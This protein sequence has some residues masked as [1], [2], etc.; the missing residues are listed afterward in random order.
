MKRSLVYNFTKKLIG[1]SAI[2][3]LLVQSL[4]A[5]S[6]FVSVAP[7]GLP[8][9]IIISELNIDGNPA[10]AGTEIGI[11]D[12]TLCVGSV[13]TDFDGQTNIDIVTWQGNPSYDLPGFTTGNTIIFKVY[14]N[15]YGE[16]EELLVTPEF[17][18]GDGTFGY[19]SF[20]TTS[21][22][23][24]SGV[25]PQISVNTEIINFGNVQLG[26]SS[27]EELI[28]SNNGTANLSIQSINIDNSQFSIGS[29]QNQIVPGLSDTINIAFYPTSSVQTQGTMTI[30]SNDPTSPNIQISL[31]GQGLP[32]DQPTIYVSTNSVNFGSVV[33][34]DSSTEV[35][36]IFN[37]GSDTLTIT[38]IYSSHTAF[39]AS[40][41]QFSIPSGES[42]SLQITFSP[43][44]Q[45]NING[46]F[47]IY[48]NAQNSSEY[49]ISLTGYG[50]LGHFQSVE[51]T[52]LPYIIIINNAT[53][54]DHNLQVGDEIGVFDGELCVG[55]NVYTGTYPT[56]L[57][58]W[59][60]DPSANLPGFSSGNPMNI[61]LWTSTYGS[62]L[63]LTPDISWIEGDGSFGSGEYSVIEISAQSGLEP[64][65]S[66]STNS[67][68]FGETEVGHAIS[69]SFYIYNSGHSQLTVNGIHSN[70]NVFW[71]DNGYFTVA[72][73]DSHMVFVY[74][75][76]AGPIPYIETITINS[77]D[78]VNLSIS[79]ELSGQGLPKQTR[80]LEV[81]ITPIQFAPTVI[82]DTSSIQL[83]LFNSGSDTINVSSVI[84]SSN[85][86]FTN[87]SSFEIT[88]GTSYQLPFLFLPDS[89]GYFDGSLTINN[90]SE[91]LPSAS[92][93]M[94]G[95][96]YENFLN[97]VEPTGIP[98]TILV[99]TLK[100]FTELIPLVGDE[101]GI[102][103][104]HLCVGAII[105]DPYIGNISGIAWQE[106]QSANLPG[107]RPG[108]PITFQYFTRVYNEPMV[109]VVQNELV[110]GDGLFGTPPYTSVELSITNI[111]VY[112]NP[113]QNLQVV[114]SLQAITLSWSANTEDDLFYYNIYRADSSNFNPDSIFFQGK[115]FTP[116][117]TFIDSLIQNNITYY[118][119][120]TAVD[121]AE[122]ESQ[123]SQYVQTTAI[124]INVWDVSFQ[125]RKDGSELVDIYYSFSGHDTTYYQSLP[126][127]SIDDGNTWT[128]I[129]Y[130]SGD[131][132]TQVLPDSIRHFIWNI[133][134]DIP[135]IYYEN[136]KIKIMVSATSPAGKIVPL[137]ERELKLERER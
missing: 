20:S 131:I 102:F 75:S 135:S 84:F 22:S 14:A 43:N 76:P 27:I 67:I 124:V 15:I 117:T 129:S 74:F 32:Q 112:L 59:E 52:G 45:G 39:S 42:F 134:E 105:V 23:I 108:Y 72:P 93:S 78:P 25:A 133:G 120:L 66:V 69:D 82:N 40:Q 95:I 79:I 3:L 80:H 13:I 73:E 137:G 91:N 17:S 1:I 94:Q 53:V 113:P 34:G 125:Q 11:F 97:A 121:T 41:I 96:G 54:D 115:I 127:L 50:Y 6:H 62:T 87:Q 10:Q 26:E 56:Q 98:Y 38:N 55:S 99:D 48:S 136:A 21:L 35:I 71:V 90:D 64:I 49:N 12:D 128:E 24:E 16:W 46:Y 63:E 70:S 106:N 109:Y 65:I 126:F 68:N 100:V 44:Y 85:N 33:V 86:F 61:K 51:S 116:D 88:P 7:T 118:Y 28:I 30:Y 58:T 101:I 123:P 37:L 8:Y 36:Q 81:S 119:K 4:F 5:Q 47:Y 114:D 19:G 2:A 110:Q 103:D 89:V 77:N 18:V 9:H 122:N 57:T 60:G 29:Y 83:T 92:I 107:F 31:I 111:P 104:G 132:G 130:I